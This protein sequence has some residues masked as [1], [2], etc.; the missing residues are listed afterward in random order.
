MSVHTYVSPDSSVCAHCHAHNHESQFYTLLSGMN[1]P[2]SSG[3][4][5]LCPL[6]IS[7]RDMYP[8]AAIGIVCTHTCNRDETFLNYLQL[9]H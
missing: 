2:T 9:R 1:E 4:T 8:Y 7:T 5:I 3:K 6:I